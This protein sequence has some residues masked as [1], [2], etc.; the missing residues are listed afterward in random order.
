ML[1]EIVRDAPLSAFAGMLAVPAAMAGIGLFVSLRAAR[2]ARIMARTP[3]SAIGLA[4]AGYAEVE[5]RVEALGGVPLTAP[6]TDAEVCWYRSKVERFVPSS[7]A[8]TQQ[9]RWA[10]ETEEASSAPFVVRDASGACVVFPDGAEVTPTDRSVWYGATPEPT[11]RDPERVGPGESAEGMIRMAGTPG[12][13]FRYTEERIYAGDPLYALGELVIRDPDVELD[14]EDE[15]G[16][17]EASAVERA[18]AAVS[19]RRLVKPRSGGQ[20]FVLST[21]P[22]EELRAAHQAGSRLALAIVALALGLASVLLWT[23]FGG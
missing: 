23:R 22:Q 11:D 4:E 17:G 8:D 3:T 21:T 9:S 6:L 16:D 7:R 13:R 12:H 10:T 5:G 1:A 19:P 15:G 18:A 14:D 2:L 20:P